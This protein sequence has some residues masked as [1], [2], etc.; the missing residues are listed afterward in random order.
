MKRLVMFDMDG[1]LFNSMPYHVK[2]WHR[3]LKDY[4]LD[5][6]E[7]VFYQNEGRTGRSMVSLLLGRDV[8]EE[9]RS[10]YSHKSLYFKAY[11]EPPVMPGALDA[12]RAVHNSGIPAS[13]VTGSAHVPLMNRLGR[14]FPGLFRSD[15]MITSADVAYGK[16]S[17]EPY[18]KGAE[19]AGV[20]ASDA[21]VVE[22]APLGIQSGH[23]AGCFVVAV[24]TGPLPDRTLLDS[25]ADVLFHS[26]SE[27]A[28]AFPFLLDQ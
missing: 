25:G 6:P 20:P 10:W 24:N 18:M 2:A 15:W 12:V 4:G 13:V 26:M 19:K 11:P 1:V 28:V 8:G 21:V 16:P 17:P 7:D 14:E 9:W 3:T 22:N 5:I 27:L 23:A